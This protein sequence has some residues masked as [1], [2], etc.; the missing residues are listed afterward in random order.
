MFILNEGLLERIALIELS[1]S[2]G[3]CIYSQ[4]EFLNQQD[5]FVLLLLNEFLKD[6]TECIS[7]DVNKIYFPKPINS[8]QRLKLFLKIFTILKKYKIDTLVI[9]TATGTELWLLLFFI[10]KSIKLAGIIHDAEKLISSSTQQKINKRIKHYF[11]LNDFIKE[12]I[13]KFNLKNLNVSSQ[14]NIFYPTENLIPISKKAN[15]FWITIPGTVEQSRRN[16]LGLIEQLKNKN[17]PESIKFLL[18]GNCNH[19]NAD[20]DLIKAK[21][22]EYNLEI[23][24]VFFDEFISNKLFLSYI[25]KSDIIMLGIESGL[26]FFNAYKKSQITGSY[27]LGFGFN[28]PLLYHQDLEHIKDLNNFG[29]SYNDNNLYETILDV[30]KNSNK[31][32]DIKTKIKNEP[33]FTFSYQQSNYLKFIESI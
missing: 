20:G 8:F 26:S 31:I 7:A 2:H 18:L 29:I 16:Y 17:I 5:N 10:P 11:V 1:S 30:S 14:Y 4:A 28:I 9:N 33:K 27:N 24:F 3:E 13:D 25:N 32:E 6:Q 23:N 19:F 22:K 12:Y 15:E 21:V